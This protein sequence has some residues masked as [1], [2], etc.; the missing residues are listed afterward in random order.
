MHFWS[1][2][3][4]KNSLVQEFASTLCVQSWEFSFKKLIFKDEKN[5]F[6]L[7][8][9]KKIHLG[10]QWSNLHSNFTEKR[11]FWPKEPPQVTVPF[12]KGAR[13]GKPWLMT[14]FFW[15]EHTHPKSPKKIRPKKTY[16]G[17]ELK[18][19]V[20]QGGAPRRVCL[21]G[22]QKFPVGKMGKINF[23]KIENFETKLGRSYRAC[24]LVPKNPHLSWFGSEMLAEWFF[25]SYP[26]NPDCTGFSIQGAIT[27]DP[28]TQFQKF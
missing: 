16:E 27:F 20:P 22:E 26:S 6:L 23:L 17:I 13:L 28:L 7:K 24:P 4:E 9:E 3:V 19:A 21:K 12:F 1:N 25:A 14:R 5:W 18:F 8:S 11:L 10:Q 15:S 2:R